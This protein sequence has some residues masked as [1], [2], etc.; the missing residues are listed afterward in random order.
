MSNNVYNGLLFEKKE[1][2]IW[3]KMFKK[4]YILI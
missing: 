1:K 4:K 2:R 3:G